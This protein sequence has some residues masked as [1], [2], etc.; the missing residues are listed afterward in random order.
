MSDGK[1][2]RYTQTDDGFLNEWQAVGQWMWD[3][4]EVYNGLSVLP[5]FGGTYKQAP[6]EDITKEEYNNRIKSLKSID[7]TKVMELDDTVDFGAIQAC[8][9]GACEVNI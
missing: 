6:F 2:S 7:L 1:G 3:N 5:F 4:R 8:G 9:G